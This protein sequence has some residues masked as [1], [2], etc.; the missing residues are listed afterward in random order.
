MVSV[1]LLVEPATILLFIVHVGHARTNLV[2][3]G[4]TA[5]HMRGSRYEE[6]PCS[7]AFVI[8]QCA[9]AMPAAAQ[10]NCL[11]VE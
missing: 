3:S 7:Y 6:Y 4:S 10:S 1:G 2:P 5:H 8:L 9:L 11:L